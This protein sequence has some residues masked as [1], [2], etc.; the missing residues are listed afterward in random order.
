MLD[1]GTGGG[2]RFLELAAEFGNG[3]GID[4]DPEMLQVARENAD[5]QSASH[6]SFG[7]IDA[8]HLRFPDRSFDV[9]L[10]RHAP[11]EVAEI[12]RVLRPGGVFITQQVGR[13]NTANIHSVFGFDPT[14]E[15]PEDFH[16]V[17]VRARVFSRADCEVTEVRRVRRRLP[18][19]RCGV[20]RV[21]AQG[22]ADAFRSRTPLARG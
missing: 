3:V 18:V 1:I 17:H 8:R 15:W 16:D 12:V 20:F 11:T 7:S 9:V 21:L 13:R 10:N 2:E 5:K 14:V 19:P 6:V 22:R 4:F